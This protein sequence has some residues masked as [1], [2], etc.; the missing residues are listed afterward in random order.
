[1]FPEQVRGLLT[2]LMK[3][4]HAVFITSGEHVYRPGF[5][6]STCISPIVVPAPV[7]AGRT[8]L[9]HQQAWP[10]SSVIP[11][12]SMRQTCVPQHHQS[13]PQSDTLPALLL[14]QLQAA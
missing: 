11:P 13:I 10:L 7:S 14:D 12:C 5:V 9:S 6:Q 1:M 2:G 3:G 4:E 8:I